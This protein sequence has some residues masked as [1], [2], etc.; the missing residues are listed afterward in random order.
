[1]GQ[2]L[3]RVTAS[4]QRTWVLAMI[5]LVIGGAVMVTRHL[6]EWTRP[7][8][9]DTDPLPGYRAVAITLSRPLQLLEW[10]VYDFIHAFGAKT[11]PDPDVVVLGID[12]ASFS[13][14]SAFPEDIEASRP[15]QLMNEVFPWSREVYAHMIERLVEGGAQTIVVDLMFPAPSGAHPEGDDVL[16]RCLEKYKN[17][18]ILA[19][20][21]ISQGIQNGQSESVQLP[22]DGLIKQK[23]PIDER[24]GFVSY[25]PDTDGVIRETRF[26]YEQDPSL[27]ERELHSFAAATLRSQGL[28]DRVPTDGLLHFVRFGDSAN[29]EPFSLHEIFIPSIWESNYGLGKR[30]AGKTIFLGTVARQQQDF[31][32]TPVGKIAGVRIHAHVYAA[33]KAGQLLRGLPQW[34]PPLLIAAAALLAWLLI[35][36]IRLPILATCTLFGVCIAAILGQFLLFNH[37]ALI[38]NSSTPTLAFGLIGICGFTYDF[39]LEQR[40]KQALKR[41]IMRFHSPD[42]AEQIVQHPESYYSIRQGAARCIVILFS[43]IRG[44]T[45]MSEQLTAQQMVTQLNEYFERMVAAVFERKGAVDKFIGDA[46]MAVWGRFRDD[47]KEAEL[48]DDAYH[49]VDAA[50]VMLEELAILNVGWRAKNMTELSIGIG[51]HQGEAVVGEIGSHERAELTAIGDC[52]NLGSRLEG[53]TKEYGLELLISDTVQARVRDRFICRSVDLVRVKGK[54]KPV[55]V[56]TVVGRH[57]MAVPMGLVHFEEGMSC[58]RQGRFG[59]SKRLFEQAA[60]E[61]MNDFLSEVFIHRSADL[62]EHPPE[63]WDGVYTMTKK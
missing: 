43:D 4:K 51:I 62:M 22:F 38:V 20:D 59:D 35:T 8:S 47:P 11:A 58:Y 30:F 50:L 12:E 49:A 15:L 39:F 10:R 3:R 52:V 34:A 36:K 16:Q 45:S 48:A 53:A 13:L 44:Y 56:F 41:S 18:V 63:N 6:E 17:H 19:A 40:Q 60:A 14:E 1:M 2:Q 57:D 55:E 29:Y 42:V 24:I 33:A 61:G 9:G 27:P 25:W 21:I 7:S 54:T 23:W 5:A 31:H 32:T 26:H 46:M 28:G 37:A